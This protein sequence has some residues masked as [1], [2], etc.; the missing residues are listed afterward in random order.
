MSLVIIDY[1][2]GNLRSVAQALRRAGHERGLASRIRVSSVAEEVAAAERILLPGVGAFGDCRAGL[3]ALPGMVEALEE[4]VIQ[5]GRPFL[6]ICV[7]MQLLAE[8]GLEHG[9]HQGLG[10]IPGQVERLQPADPALKI[11]HMGWNELQLTPAGEAHPV[12]AGLSSGVHAYF[13]HSYHFRPLEPEHLLAS[14]DH[15]MKF[16]A[17]LGRDNLIATQFHPEKSQAAG[18]HFLGNF[19]EWKS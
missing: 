8:R 17:V 18:L 4:A 3:D 9:L 11:P 13:V 19:L 6:G 10:W 7:G 5:Q 15:G 12:L 1:G 14:V 16:A 2:S